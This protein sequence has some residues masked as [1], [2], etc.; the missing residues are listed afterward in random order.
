M[1]LT[2]TVVCRKG[3]DIAQM[4]NSEFGLPSVFL[5]E[6]LTSF[7]SYVLAITTRL[8]PDNHSP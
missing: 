8:V 2:L 5:A 1:F 6:S 3:A 4:T 7:P